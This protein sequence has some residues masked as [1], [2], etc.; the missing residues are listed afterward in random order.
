ML[1]PM[2]TQVPPAETYEPV[3]GLPAAWRSGSAGTAAARA[4]TRRRGA[5]C[6]ISRTKARWVRRGVMDGTDTMNSI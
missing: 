3:G 2:P 1:K 6:V 5:R 4:T